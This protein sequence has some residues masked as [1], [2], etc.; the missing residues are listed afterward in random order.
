LPLF[1]TSEHEV[2][3]GAATSEIVFSETR[4]EIEALR[5]EQTDL[6]ENA[7]EDPRRHSGE[8][9]RQELRKGIE[10]Y[11]EKIQKLPGAAGSGF[12]SGP[13]KGHFFCAKVGDRVFLRFIHW[14]G[15]DLVRDTLG[16]LRIITCREDTPRS[17]PEDLANGAYAAWQKARRDIFEEWSFATDPANLQP[18]VRPALRTAANNLRK[19]PPPGITQEE[20]VYLIESLEAPWGARIEK[21]IREAMEGLTGS[22]ASASIAEKVKLLGLQPYRAPDPLP[23]IEEDEIILVCWLAVGSEISG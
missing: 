12:V 22:A 14:D 16:C 6:F 1:I 13:E 9:Y 3:P 7:G 15:K 19:F 10:F 4:A 11:G 8:E 18:R 23:P 2:I 5:R 17:L 21:V 20:L